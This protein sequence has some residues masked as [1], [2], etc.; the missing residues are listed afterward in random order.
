MPAGSGRKKIIDLRTNKIQKKIKQTYETKFQVFYELTLKKGV[1]FVE[2]LKNCF[3]I[4]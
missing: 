4:T 2:K 1:T 3:K